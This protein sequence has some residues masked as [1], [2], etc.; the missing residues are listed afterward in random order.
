MSFRKTRRVQVTKEGVKQR[1]GTQTSFRGSSR[2]APGVWEGSGAH[3]LGSGNVLR[4]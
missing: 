1:R 3:N 4:R 2:G